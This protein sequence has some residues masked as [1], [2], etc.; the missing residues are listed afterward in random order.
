M[1]N[2]ITLVSHYEPFIKHKNSDKYYIW[3]A[4]IVIV[5]GKY[6]CSVHLGNCQNGAKKEWQKEFA[7][8]GEAT[9][10]CCRATKQFEPFQIKMLT[11][12]EFYSGQ[13]YTDFFKFICH[14]WS[15]GGL[16]D[17]GTTSKLR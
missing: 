16:N 4:S 2:K 8:L 15:T 6:H 10:F 17:I 14:I 12:D 1:N 13:E 5:D 7:S 11:F 9:D 3:S